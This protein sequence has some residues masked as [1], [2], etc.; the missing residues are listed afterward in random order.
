MRVG[1]IDVDVFGCL[2]C[3]GV[4]TCDVCTCKETI[5][6]N[7]SVVCMVSGMV[8]HRHMYSEEQFV[9]TVAM[10]GSVSQ[11]DDNIAA[12]VDTSVQHML[13]SASSS[14]QH[15]NAFCDLLLQ[16]SRG[17]SCTTCSSPV[18]KLC[19]RLNTNRMY[20]DSSR[21]I[22]GDSWCESQPTSVGAF[23]NS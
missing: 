19:E 17:T 4:H 11:F 9:Y 7:D 14:R 6:T 1:V 22:V 16:W 23:C 15:S 20:F 13:L 18:L 8:L 5:N 10:T 12:E 3:G 21:R 2:I